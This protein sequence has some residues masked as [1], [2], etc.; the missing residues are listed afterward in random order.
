M[1]SVQDITYHTTGSG[2]LGALLFCLAIHRSRLAITNYNWSWPPW[3][4]S[5][6][7]IGFIWWQSTLCK[8][9]AKQ[10]QSS[11]HC[12]ACEW[13]GIC[14]L[15]ILYWK[16][17]LSREFRFVDASDRGCIGAVSSPEQICLSMPSVFLWLTTFHDPSGLRANDFPS[18][19]VL[20][21]SLKAK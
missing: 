1:R 16:Q 11:L 9:K 19:F 17:K 8:P 5:K 7:T 13:K 12:G 14:L 18:I 4:L 2:H 21:K 6:W 3:P 15:S 20:Y 10:T